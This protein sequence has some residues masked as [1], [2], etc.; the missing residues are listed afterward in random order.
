MKALTQDILFYKFLI[1]LYHTTQIILSNKILWGIWKP[2]IY[3]TVIPFSIPF[4]EVT[5]ILDLHLSSQ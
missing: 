4:L 5:I 3:P 1:I 2:F